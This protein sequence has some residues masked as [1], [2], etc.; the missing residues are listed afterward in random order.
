MC[1]VSA[2]ERRPCAASQSAQRRTV[3]FSTLSCRRR[4]RAKFRFFQADP[5]RTAFA[6]SSRRLRGHPL[7]DSQRHV[8]KQSMYTALIKRTPTVAIWSLLQLKN[9]V[10]HQCLRT[11][12]WVI[13]LRNKNSAT[14]SVNV[15]WLVTNLRETKMKG[16]ELWDFSAPKTNLHKWW[17]LVSQ[18]TQFCYFIWNTKSQTSFYK[19]VDAVIHFEGFISSNGFAS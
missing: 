8:G 1:S 2:G 18:L 19:D 10:V 16:S 14:S 3:I 11:C 4:L 6:V 15:L 7:P 5:S 12:T 17:R 13:F 9:Q